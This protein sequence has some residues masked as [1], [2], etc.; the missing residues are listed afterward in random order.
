MSPKC[1]TQTI[2]YF[3]GVELHQEY[4]VKDEFINDDYKK[5]II[6]REDIIERFLSGFNEDLYSNTC[7]DNMNITFH[8]CVQCLYQHYI[9]KTPELRN[10]HIND[11]NYPIWF[12]EE[13]NSIKLSITDECGNFCSHILSQTFSIKNI[14]DLIKGKNVFIVEL[15]NL[16]KLLGNDNCIIKNRK[17]KD[18]TL[19]LSF[20]NIN[21]IKEKCYCL[22]S[23]NI[24]KEDQNIILDMYLE[25]INFINELKKEYDIIT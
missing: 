17:D 14:T 16:H 9:K 10:L 3:L 5:Y 11:V 4:D 1:G 12:G 20:M 7:Y 23:K 6:F 21:E 13:P 22:T 25:D 15:N 18:E 2:S 19:N 8:D 24:N